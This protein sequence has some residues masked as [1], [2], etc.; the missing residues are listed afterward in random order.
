MNTAPQLPLRRPSFFFLFRL[1]SYML[2]E[3]KD[4]MRTNLLGRF[5]I[6]FASSH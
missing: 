2:I 4:S 3:P 5:Y 1:I 6:T